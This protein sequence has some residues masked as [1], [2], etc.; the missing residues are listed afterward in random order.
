[1]ADKGFARDDYEEF[2]A[3][4]DLDLTLIRPARKNE[5]DQGT[6]PNWLRQLVEA[7]IW[8]LKKPA[9]PGAP[10]RPGSGALWT[11]GD[12]LPSGQ[13]GGCPGP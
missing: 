1:M 3:G 10:R 9:R 4:P 6:F 5:K 11:T 2:L 7:V 8:T 13:A 12:N